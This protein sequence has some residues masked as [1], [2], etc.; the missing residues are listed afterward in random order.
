MSEYYQQANSPGTGSGGSSASIRA[1]F[2]KA[3][4]AFDMLPVMA[5]NGDKHMTVN[6]SASGLS[7]L[8]FAIT[9]GGPVATLTSGITLNLTGN[10]SVTIPAA[11]GTLLQAGSSKLTTNGV[12]TPSLRFSTQGDFVP[13]YSTRTG[14]YHR[15]GSIIIVSWIVIA[16]ALTYTTASGTLYINGL[17]FAPILHELFPGSGQWEG[18]AA[19]SV[20]VTNGQNVYATNSTTFGASIWPGYNEPT[21]S[22]LVG[23]G[24]LNYLSGPSSLSMSGTAVYLTLDA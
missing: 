22:A 2:A 14:Q 20:G 4:L 15:F 9:L 19:G 18:E 24:T 8:S 12:W 23:V 13:T 11:S 16:S 21:I 10:T 3:Q 5:G 17:P 6:A 7:S 1:E